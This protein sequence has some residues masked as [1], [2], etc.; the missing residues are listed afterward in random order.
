MKAN[1]RKTLHPQLA[2][3]FTLTEL[4]VVTLIVVT[5][6][7]F[8]VMGIRSIRQSAQL[9]RCADNLRTWGVAIHGY[10]AEN[11]G[12]VQWRDWASI[13]SSARYYEAYLGGDGVAATATMDGASVL[14]TQLHRRCPS[15]KWNKTGNGPVGYAMVR[16]N[17]KVSEQEFYNLSTASDA[18]QLLMMIDAT[19]L[20]LNG[21]GDLATSVAPLC[22]GGNSRHRNTVNALFGDGHVSGYRS[23]D[24][25]GGK[26]AQKAM[27]ERWFNLR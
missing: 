12:N 14:S 27:R 6:A 17:P 3:G 5:I 19:A 26:T 10:A 21:T 13:G 18:S 15:Q 1:T 2:S 4:L 8:S 23:E 22:A 24:I 9:A 7:A 16:P 11:N 20:N 25:I